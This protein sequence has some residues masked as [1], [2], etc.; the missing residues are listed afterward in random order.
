MCLEDLNFGE[1]KIGEGLQ[2]EVVWE[3]VRNCGGVERSWAPARET[4][5]PLKLQDNG[6]ESPG[7]R[8]GLS[9]YFFTNPVTRNIFASTPTCKTSC[10]EDSV[11]DVLQDALAAAGLS[12]KRF[13]PTKARPVITSMGAMDVPKFSRVLL[14][15]LGTKMFQFPIVS[16]AA[17]NPMEMEKLLKD[18][19]DIPSSSDEFEIPEHFKNYTLNMDTS[20]K[21]DQDMFFLTTK[22]ER[23]ARE[24]GVSY[25][26]SC[27]ITKFQASKVARKV[28]REY[29]P[30][31]KLGVF[32]K[33]NPETRSKETIFNTYIPPRWKIWARE[34]PEKFKN[35]PS[36][37][38]VAVDK[39][40]KHLIPNSEE[41]RYLRAWMY[42]S[43]TSRSFVYLVLCG[44]PGAG[45]NRLRYM[46][47]ALH[48]GSNLIAGKPT[49][50]KD[51]FNKQLSTGTLHW[52]D[53]LRYDMDMENV[54]KE[55]QNETISIEAKGVDATTSTE[56][57]GSVVISNNKPRDNYLEF[58]ARKFAPLVL[59]PNDL[60][61]SMT[62]EEI[63]TLTK[64]LNEG[65]EG[66]DPAYVAQIAKWILSTGRA[67]YERN[68]SLEYRGPMF[69]KLAHTSMAKWQK[70]AVV[71][72]IDKRSGIKTGWDSIEG[73]HLWSKV[74]EKILKK[75]EG[76]KGVIFPDYSTVQAFFD[77]FR[78]GAGV[79]AF[80]TKL[81]PG[82][83]I[84]G[85]FW[86]YPKI[87]GKVDIMTAASEAHPA[88]KVK[89]DG[90]EEI[91]D[92]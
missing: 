86:I 5:D 23:I 34:N 51:K 52:F 16:Q 36:A 56:I 78:D 31:G 45:K 87:S 10:E 19:E 8:P 76:M 32:D 6:V 12:V 85:D 4:E 69:W 37:P 57:H 3:A 90:Q 24:S 74:E 2:T 46:M 50:L 38:P 41:R 44:A 14:E 65:K 79:K 48:G 62:E 55:I 7:G 84:L 40:L 59:A 53:E 27:G 83:N 9:I 70:L 61:H 77:V 30:R 28:I 80:D 13:D 72:L 26:T 82:D 39:L 64:K 17:M 75:S 20:E 33:K 11:T 89:N 35:L 1:H 63:G 25:I 68:T 88:R 54:M 58:N 18:F 67:N 66:F 92:L 73:A 15:R 81:V 43:M 22:N 49:T 91:L 60:K 42:A 47:R 29:L 71:T 21:K